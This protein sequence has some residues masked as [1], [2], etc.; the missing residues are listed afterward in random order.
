MS[1][2]TMINGF[3]ST[4]I[5]TTQKAQTCL[6]K[7]QNG[8]LIVTLKAQTFQMKNLNGCIINL[9]SNIVC[10]PSIL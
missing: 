5:F 7:N 10:I 1:N 4:S 8:C 6:M 9:I 3:T 2:L